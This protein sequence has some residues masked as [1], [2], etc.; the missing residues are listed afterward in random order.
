MSPTGDEWLRAS[1]I[2]HYA[3]CARAWWL[4]RVKG[5]QSDNTEALGRGLALHSAHGRAVN[6]VLRQRR[7]AFG[8]LAAA[9]VCLMLVLWQWVVG[10]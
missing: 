8:L 6:A 9:A 2:G 10:P 3:Y 1:E 5:V 7:W 4:Q